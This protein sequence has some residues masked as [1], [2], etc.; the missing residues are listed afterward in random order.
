MGQSPGEDAAI[1]GSAITS[2]VGAGL[3]IEQGLRAAAQELPRGRTTKA[4]TTLAG[5]LECGETFEHA[6]ADSTVP[7]HLRALVVAG[8]RSA[9]L[10]RVLEEFVAGER[11]AA[12]V[13]RRIMVAISYPA[14]LMFLMS[15]LFAFAA[16]Y[17]VPGIMQI[18][19][20]F[21]A[22][23][24]GVTIALDELSRSGHW[25]LL[26]NVV[27]LSAGWILLWL[28]LKIAELRMILVSVPLLGPTIHWA[29]LARFSR[30]LAL[31]VDAELPLPK[32]LELAGSGCQDSI[33]EYASKKAAVHVRSG[34]AL[35]DA[36]MARRQFPR[37][38]SPIVRWGERASGR[39][40]PTSALGDALRT[41]AEM[42]DGRLDA[43]LG[44]LRAVTAP[45]SFL[46]VVW[47]AIFI[48]AATM[49]P[50]F[51]L[52]EKLT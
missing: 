47:G 36:L 6:A 48:V 15:G 18:Y 38:L 7:A 5:K 29:A 8:L 14:L 3:P 24:P 20:E 13:N 51:S 9:S 49:L 22:D 46:F 17:V 28:A 32:A 39:Q 11:H 16:L 10:G 27:V 23:L 19:D 1:L 12:D 45:L 2:L 50:M 30:M 25:L 4:L 44:L 37:S 33:L 31:L 42:F 52:L 40:S 35:S 21:D 41:A 26:G 43:Q 34:A